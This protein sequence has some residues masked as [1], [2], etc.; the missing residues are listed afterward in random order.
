MRRFNGI[1]VDAPTP[2]CV[3]GDCCQ[4][5]QQEEVTQ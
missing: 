4:N 2:C 5:L 1:I 3:G